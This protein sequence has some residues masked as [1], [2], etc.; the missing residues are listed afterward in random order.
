M[1]QRRK[2]SALRNWE[3]LVSNEVVI[4]RKQGRPLDFPMVSAGSLLLSV[5]HSNRTVHKKPDL[6]PLN[7]PTKAQFGQV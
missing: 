7:L 3:M 4:A 6:H 5:G 1:Y 2:N